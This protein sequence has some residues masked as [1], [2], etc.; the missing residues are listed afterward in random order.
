MA[1]TFAWAIRGARVVLVVDT[2]LELELELGL[3]I[4][5]VY[6]QV[7]VDVEESCL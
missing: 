3:T 2:G 4:F 1:M 7:V 5:A 6:G